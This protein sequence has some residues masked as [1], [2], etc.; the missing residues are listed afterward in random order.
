MGKNSIGTNNRIMIGITRMKM[1]M[2]KKE[3]RERR[4]RMMMM[5]TKKMRR[6]M[7]LTT[8]TKLRKSIISVLLKSKKLFR[9]FRV[10]F[11]K[12]LLN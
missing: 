2:K 5:K 8:Q 11:P 6:K 3:M 7:S 1:R 9:K 10:S 12:T 4:K